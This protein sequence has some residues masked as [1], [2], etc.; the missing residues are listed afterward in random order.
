[1]VVDVMCVCNLGWGWL[2]GGN[3]LGG[4]DLGEAFG[5]KTKCFPSV[6][7]PSLDFCLSSLSVPDW[8]TL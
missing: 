4:V 1:M 6:L 7:S 5:V 3:L 2:V 8:Q